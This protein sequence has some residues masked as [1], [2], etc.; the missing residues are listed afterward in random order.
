MACE[1]S[2]LTSHLAGAA[3]LVAEREPVA[4]TSL[5]ELFRYDGLRVYEAADSAAA[6]HHIKNDR[7]TGVIMLDTEMPSWRSVVTHAQSRLPGALI[8][9]MS[10]QDSSRRTVDAHRLGVHGYLVKPLV[11]D[12]VCET[13]VRLLGGRPLR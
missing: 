6:I 9:A 2:S 3:I 1:H 4:R 12:N 13:I 10:T 7:T 8:L 5:S 11:F